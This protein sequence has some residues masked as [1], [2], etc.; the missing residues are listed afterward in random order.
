MNIVANALNVDALNPSNAAA[1]RVLFSYKMLHGPDDV[2]MTLLNDSAK[3]REGCGFVCRCTVSRGCNLDL[4]F[5][6]GFGVSISFF[7]LLRRTNLAESH[8]LNAVS[9]VLVL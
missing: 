1:F 7:L 2:T 5:S 9:I 4:R 6:V 8:L 3:L